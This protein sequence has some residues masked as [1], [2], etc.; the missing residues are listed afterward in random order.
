MSSWPIPG[1]KP[2]CAAGDRTRGTLF[3]GRNSIGQWYRR[4]AHF[5]RQTEPSAK[6][7]ARAASC[8]VTPRDRPIRLAGY[9]L[10][11]A[12]VSTILDPI[13]ISAMLLECPGQRCL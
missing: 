7:L 9:A 4:T 6:L 10:R 13:E 5:N 12:P 11:E 1:T 3:W 2:Y 8:D